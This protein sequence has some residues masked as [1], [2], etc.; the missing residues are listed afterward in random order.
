MLTHQ[1]QLVSSVYSACLLLLC[2]PTHPLP[3]F[4][5]LHLLTYLHTVTSGS[6][7][8]FKC[9]LSQ[10]S[11]PFILA[12]SSRQLGHLLMLSQLDK[13]AIYSC[14]QPEKWVICS[15]LGKQYI[16]PSNY[17]KMRKSFLGEIEGAFISVLGYSTTQ[18]SEHYQNIEQWIC[19]LDCTETQ[20]RLFLQNFEVMSSVLIAGYTQGWPSVVLGFFSLMS[21]PSE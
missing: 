13:W 11:G 15:Q 21:F 4:N 16:L 12:V 8:M 6:S 20:E 19:L 17:N 7:V 5:Y 1:Q 14:N 3:T 18:W 10:R 2:Q 9:Y